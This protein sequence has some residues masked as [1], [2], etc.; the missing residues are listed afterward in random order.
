MKAAENGARLEK[1]GKFI[2]DK[3]VV[4]K[5]INKSGINI[6]FASQNLK[7]DREVIIQAVSQMGK[8]I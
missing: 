7:D 5:S 8:A 6:K 2:N 3:D 4:L 1:M